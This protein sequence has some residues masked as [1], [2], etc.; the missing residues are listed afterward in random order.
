VPDGRA[1]DVDGA[2]AAYEEAIRAAG[3]IGLQLLGLGADG[4]IGFN[5]PTSSL[6]SRTRLKTLTAAT[7][8][9]MRARLPPGAEP[10]RHV[11]TMGI[12]TIL[13]ARR[14]LVLAL[15][16]RKAEAVARMVEGPVTALVPASALQ[17]HP[18]TTVFVDEEAAARLAL[19]RYYRDVFGSKP[20]WQRDRD[21][22]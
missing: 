12:G 14:C 5:E 11:L 8:A 10:P 7:L 21:G 13:E 9:G 17:L 18:R 3:G 20:G 22:L 16:A 6:A 4:H 15:G 19:A 1:A 2:C